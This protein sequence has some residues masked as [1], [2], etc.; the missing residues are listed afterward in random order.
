[1][2]NERTIQKFRAIYILK[3]NLIMRIH[4]G[5]VSIS[6]TGFCIGR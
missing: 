3:R 5:M 6:E 4:A 1:M 2:L